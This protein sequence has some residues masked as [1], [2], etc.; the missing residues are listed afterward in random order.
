MGSRPRVSNPRP[1]G[2]DP[3]SASPLAHQPASLAAFNR[4]Y[5]TLWSRGVVD[6]ASKEVA[7]IRNA[8]V[9]DCRLCRSLRFA[10]ARAEGLSE[11]RVELI[12]DDF[13]T[14]DLAPRYKAVLRLTDHFLRG[15]GPPPAALREELARHF[16][17]EQVVELVAGLALFYGFSKIA[18]SL[19]GL[20]ESLPVMEVPTPSA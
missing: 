13:E 10:G 3:V 20:P 17:P 6:Q 14:S 1:I 2:P 7:R 5:G 19:G 16:S 11:D 18:V 12:R 4:L 8:R 9:I 15:S